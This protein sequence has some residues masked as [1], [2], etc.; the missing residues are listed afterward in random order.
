[1]LFRVRQDAGIESTNALKPTEDFNIIEYLYYYNGGGVAATDINGDGLPDLYFTNNQQPNKYYINEG[2]WQFRDA[3]EEGEVAGAG[4][5]STGVSITDVNQDGRQDIYVC[6]VSGYKGLTGKN[7]LFVQ[8]ADGTF[9]EQAA[10]YGLDF[11]GF[12]TQAYWFDY[13]LDGDQ[14]MYLLRHSVHNDATY[15]TAQGREIMDSLAGDL[16]LRNDVNSATASTPRFVNVT[17]AAGM[18]SSKIGYGLSAAITDFD[19]NGYP[20]LYVCN[21]FSENDYYYLNQGDGTFR[22]SVRERMGH[23]S[24]FSMGNDLLD[25]DEDGRPD[26]LTLDMRPSDEVVLKH[27]A[28][29]DAYNVYA[30]KRELGYYDQVP[31]NNLQWNRGD[32]YFTEIGQLVGLEA[33][34]WSWSVL[35]ED[36]DFDG[37][38]EVFVANGIERRPNDLDYLKFISSDLARTATNLELAEQMPPGRVAN[39]FYDQG[40]YFEFA[41]RGEDTDPS[42]LEHVG[43]STGA[44]VAD[45]DGD[46]DLDVVVTHLNEPASI[47]ENTL[48]EVA[49]SRDSVALPGTSAMVYYRVEDN[50]NYETTLRIINIQ[51]VALRSGAVT[52]RAYLS[53]GTMVM[54]AWGPQRG[55][56]SQSDDRFSFRL[57]EGGGLDSLI[58][59]DATAGTATRYVLQ[60]GRLDKLQIGPA[61][62]MSTSPAAR[63]SVR[64]TPIVHQSR[65]A[66]DFDR[67]PLRPWAA[68]LGAPVV[69]QLAGEPLFLGGGD[70]APALYRFDGEKLVTLAEIDTEDRVTAAVY[71]R[72]D[73]TRGNHLLIGDDR[74][75]LRLYDQRGAELTDCEECLPQLPFIPSHILAGD[76]DE[77]GDQDLLVLTQ[78]DGS[79]FGERTPV[80]RLDNR[81]NGTM[82]TI[83]LPLAGMRDAVWIRDNREI[84]AVGPWQQLKLVDLAGEDWQVLDF[85]PA[86]LYHSVS[87]VE[88]PD[89]T[90][91]LVVGN[92]TRN[93]SLGDP[94][95]EG[96]LFLYRDDLD[97]NGR[98][99]PLITYRRNAQEYSWADKDELGTQLP[100]LRRNNLSYADFSRRSVD[101][102]FPELGA[103]V[104][105]AEELD[106][107]ILYKLEAEDVEWEVD[108]LAPELQPVPVNHEILD[109]ERMLLAGNFTTVLPRLGR[110]DGAALQLIDEAGE[111]SVIDLGGVR[112]R[113]MIT[114]IVPLDGRHWL[115][116][117]RE[118]SH[119]I[120]RREQ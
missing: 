3:T 74:G 67:E 20:D 63:Y 115:L 64:E 21:D 77:D 34:D 59:I 45:F 82:D 23:S 28:N 81:G 104:G 12:N 66:Q 9:R 35:S 6:N 114:K 71:V 101:E 16:L 7:E 84:I 56:L 102:S 14:D 1:M 95:N 58:R 47:Y 91:E 18:Y 55:Q 37:W 52:Y 94:Y 88:F 112:N 107:L 54:R 49:R 85:G 111:V 10:D 44:A 17:A 36:F 105:T 22:E 72:L 83:R 13:D 31:R 100:S 29:A 60:W 113:S 87:L 117:V 27:T 26:L 75:K 5:W 46:G 119:L 99:D 40:P 19:Q 57:P 15:G 65:V 32:G 109:G 43:S 50:S 93:T 96:P 103:P 41:P 42:G 11:A 120:L 4:S 90:R 61:G 38:K 68:P 79:S 33:S 70:G 8:Q 24:Q 62:K 106:N 118:G 92:L 73:S 53:D 110:L 97:G 89:S 2:N 30:I 25:L 78:S 48:L 69:A 98:R 108:Y 51:D 39:Q 80:Y 86:G 76:F 116:V